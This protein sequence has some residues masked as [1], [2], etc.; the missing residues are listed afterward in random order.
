MLIGSA[1]KWMIL[2]Y[3]GPKAYRKAVKLCA[4]LILGDFVIGGSWNLIGVLFNTPT[5][6]FWPGSYL[7]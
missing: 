5:Y 6:S 2:K 4:G 7:P 3:G 1:A